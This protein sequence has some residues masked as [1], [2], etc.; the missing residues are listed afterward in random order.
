MH[1]YMYIMLFLLFVIFSFSLKP[2]LFNNGE[3]GIIFII[4]RFPA[5][6]HLYV[7]V[8]LCMYVQCPLMRCGD[9]QEGTW[10][11][12]HIVWQR[13][14][15]IYCRE[16][17]LISIQM[18]LCWLVSMPP[19][20]TFLY[21]L[22]RPLFAGSKISVVFENFVILRMSLDQNLKHQAIAIDTSFELGLQLVART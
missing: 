10:T 11:F 22:Y 17:H 9:W 5:S 14:C 20:L 7:Y 3:M 18:Q 19:S 8:L 16:S 6:I 15:S 12:G 21:L 13:L 1:L 4:Y 2:K